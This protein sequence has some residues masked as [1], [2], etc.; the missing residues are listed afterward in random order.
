MKKIAFEE[1][2]CRPQYMALRF[3]TPRGRA[4]PFPLNPKEF[5]RMGPLINDEGELRLKDMDKYEIE[6]SAL[7]SATNGFDYVDDPV[8]DKANVMGFN[9]FL[10]GEVVKK[11]PDR[12]LGFATLPIL[13]PNQAA[14]EMYRC[15]E[16]DGCLGALV[17]GMTRPGRFLDEEEYTPVW[18]AAHK[19]KA[20]LYLHPTE[21]PEEIKL[22]YR[23]YECLN[24]ST[25]S[26]GT[27][28]ATYVLR[29]I[30]SGLFDRY[31]DVKLIVGHM[32]EMLP[33]V[34]ERLDIRWKISPL[35][36]KNKFPPSE[37]IKR[38]IWITTSG[39][40][41]AAAMKCAIEAIGSDKI[42]FATDYPFE[43]MGE[44]SE[45]I[46]NVDISEEDRERICWKNATAM[47]GL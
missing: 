43:G 10:F 18:E 41:S 46:E 8:E 9:D 40:P 6:K 28:T 38:N 5:E 36:S 19:T 33:Y 31:P 2:I 47:F 15:M 17:S 11:H 22:L 34:L 20:Y 1:H 12:F 44:Y 24:G 25:W 16:M 39:N 32:G 27:D 23:N 30:F 13:D 29:M 21:T 7:I 3:T 37:Y 4:N 42:L 35:D 45:F 14:D 26:W